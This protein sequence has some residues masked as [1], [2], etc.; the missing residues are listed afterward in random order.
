MTCTQI[1]RPVLQVFQMHI[2]TMLKACQPLGY[3]KTTTIFWGICITSWNNLYC[4]DQLPL[5]TV[6]TAEL[7]MSITVNF[8]QNAYESLCRLWLWRQLSCWHLLFPDQCYRC[9]LKTV[10]SCCDWHSCRQYSQWL[11]EDCSENWLL[12]IEHSKTCLHNDNLWIPTVSYNVILKD[13]LV[14]NTIIAK[15]ETVYICRYS[16]ILVRRHGSNSSLYSTSYQIDFQHDTRLGL[17]VFV[18]AQ[19]NGWDSVGMCTNWLDYLWLCIVGKGLQRKV[20]HQDCGTRLTR[21]S[22]PSSDTLKKVI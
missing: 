14:Y 19:L 9:R 22:E 12:S 1:T 4:L 16:S 21:L 15:P 6:I 10:Q 8:A 5:H 3:N 13:C 17:W 18:L 7:W 2:T 20:I 11:L